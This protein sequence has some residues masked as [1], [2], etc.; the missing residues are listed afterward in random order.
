[1]AMKMAMSKNEAHFMSN[2]ADS[3]LSYGLCSKGY[4]VVMCNNFRLTSHAIFLWETGNVPESAFSPI[5][6]SY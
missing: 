1:M 5:G 6:N 4:A 3:R 2:V